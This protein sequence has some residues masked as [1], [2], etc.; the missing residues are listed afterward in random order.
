MNT[1]LIVLILVCAIVAG[2]LGLTATI[3]IL[4]TQRRVG[5]HERGQVPPRPMPPP[6]PVWGQPD[7]ATVQFDVRGLRG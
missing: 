5:Y 4:A 3:I 1:G 6:P 2:N 7:D